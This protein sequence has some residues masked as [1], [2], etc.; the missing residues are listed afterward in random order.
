MNAVGRF[1]FVPPLPISALF[2]RLCSCGPF[3][4]PDLCKICVPWRRFTLRS[5]PFPRPL[6]PTHGQVQADSTSQQSFHQVGSE[7]PTSPCGSVDSLDAIIQRLDQASSQ[8]ETIQSQVPDAAAAGGQGHAEQSHFDS[9][10]EDTH[11]ITLDM[12]QNLLEAPRSQDTS[13]ARPDRWLCVQKDLSW[14]SPR[15]TTGRKKSRSRSSG[16]GAGRKSAMLRQE[17]ASELSVPVHLRMQTSVWAVAGDATY[18][19]AMYYQGGMESTRA[20]FQMQSADELLRWEKWAS[21]T[22]DSGGGEA[23]MLNVL[24][25]ETG[26]ATSLFGRPTAHDL[27]HGSAVDQVEVVSVETPSPTFLDRGPQLPE[28]HEV[29]SDFE[30]GMRKILERSRIDSQIML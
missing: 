17:A 5:E 4:F 28:P 21:D 13:A 30:A 22:Q 6:L 16:G 27:L 9:G 20:T 29:T 12:D 23:P 10:S 26:D 18:I 24:R 11:V 15:R 2:F 14:M 7:G 8:G 3:P 25:I 1:Q 19:A